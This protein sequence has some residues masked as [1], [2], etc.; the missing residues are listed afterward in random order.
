M[1]VTLAALGA[2]ITTLTMSTNRAQALDFLGAQAYQAV[3]A[4]LDY[5]VRQAMTASTC[6]A[7]TT[8]EP[9]Q[10]DGR[11]RI[12]VECTSVS[13]DDYC[14]RAIEGDPDGA[15]EETACTTT[16]YQIV[17]TACGKRPDV[18]ADA[19][20]DPCPGNASAGYVERQMRIT[21]EGAGS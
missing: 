4:G 3:N 5:G 21:I 1:V 8:L 11:F 18:G 2:A 13:T 15:T 12:K 14:V 7:S 10:W 17:A 16:V 20:T 19:A 9:T 6:A